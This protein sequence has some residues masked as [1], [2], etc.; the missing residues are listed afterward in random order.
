MKEALMKKRYGIPAALLI[1][2]LAAGAVAA[3]FSVIYVVK[4]KVLEPTSEKT[5]TGPFAV[6]AGGSFSKTAKLDLNLPGKYKLKYKLTGNGLVKS[7]S[8]T[9]VIDT[10]DEANGWLDGGNDEI[11]KTISAVDKSVTFSASKVGSGQKAQKITVSGTVVDKTLATIKMISAGDD[12]PTAREK[13][14][15]TLKVSMEPSKA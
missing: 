3:T 9:I 11:S 6:P 8:A 7:A 14:T 2:L 4:P 1:A 12:D 13:G 5:S 15:A 10:D